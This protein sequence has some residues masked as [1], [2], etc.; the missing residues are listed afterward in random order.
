MALPKP[1]T[2]EKSSVLVNRWCLGNPAERFSGKTAI[3]W[4]P[5]RC[6]SGCSNGQTVPALGAARADDRPASAGRH[7]NEKAMSAFAA[8]H[9]RLISAFH[10]KVPKV[11]ANQIR[12]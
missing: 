6:P 12:N 8:N 3:K 9:R 5:N 11:I 4:C 1:K 2:D 10:D 7:A